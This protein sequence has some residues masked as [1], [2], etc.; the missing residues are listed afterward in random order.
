MVLI[1]LISRAPWPSS[2]K[3][4][5][6]IEVAGLLVHGV[7]LGGVFTAISRGLPEGVASLV[8]GVQPLLTAV[9]AGRLLGAKVSTRQ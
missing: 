1:A 9:G 3:V 5:F 6:H 7:Y 2:G 8:V 4:W